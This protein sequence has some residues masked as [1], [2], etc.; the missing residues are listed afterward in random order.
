MQQNKTKHKSVMGSQNLK[1]NNFETED[2][3]NF[4]YVATCGNQ[5]LTFW[6]NRIVSKSG[7]NYLMLWVHIPVEWSP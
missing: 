5:F 1:E 6:D 3:F 7:T 4:W 2:S